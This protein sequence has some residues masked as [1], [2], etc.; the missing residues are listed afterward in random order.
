MLMLMTELFGC[1]VCQLNAYLIVK[2]LFT[3]L[4]IQNLMFFVS[5]KEV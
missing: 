4:E 5:T 2:I 1:L 3:T